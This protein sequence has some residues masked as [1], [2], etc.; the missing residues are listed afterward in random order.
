MH[1]HAHTHPLSYMPGL[2]GEVV[3]RALYVATKINKPSVRSENAEAT[4]LWIKSGSSDFY[5][6][7]PSII[8]NVHGSLS[9]DSL[10]DEVPGIGKVWSLKTLSLAM[11]CGAHACRSGVV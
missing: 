8:K 5:R 7:Q 10:M 6:Q 1:T 2:A 3:Q 4:F 9:S 11:E